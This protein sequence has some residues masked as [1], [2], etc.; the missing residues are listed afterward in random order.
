MTPAEALD[1]RFDDPD[2]G[3]NMTIREYFRLLLTTLYEEGEGFSGK[4]PLG[5]SGWDTNLEAVLIQ[6]GCIAGEVTHIEEDGDD[7][8]EVEDV[9]YDVYLA[10]VKSMIAAM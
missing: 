7:Y 10:F 5:N 8:W 4:R 6:H 1:L 2:T 9:E 3:E